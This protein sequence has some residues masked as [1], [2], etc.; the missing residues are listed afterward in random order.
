MK[1]TLLT[2]ILAVSFSACSAVVKQ[3]IN[4]KKVGYDRQNT[5]AEKALK[6]I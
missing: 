3:D 1:K 4:E 6:D 2:I 5:A